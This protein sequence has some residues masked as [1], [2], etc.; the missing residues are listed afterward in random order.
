MSLMERDYIRERY[1]EKNNP[2]NKK[3][4]SGFG[5]KKSLESELDRICEDKRKQKEYKKQLFD[6]NIKPHI[7]YMDE[8]GNVSKKSN[9]YFSDNDKKTIKQLQKQS[10]NRYIRNKFINIL[11]ILITVF[12]ILYLSYDLYMSSTMVF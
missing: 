9:L 6:R 12:L 4:S 8:N 1:N 7:V 3:W 11:I 2:T 10:K 5:S